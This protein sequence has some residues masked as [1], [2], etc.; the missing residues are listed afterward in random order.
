MSEERSEELKGRK[1]IKERNEGNKRRKQTMIMRI[2]I[3]FG[4]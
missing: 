1:E 3:V 2:E 4:N